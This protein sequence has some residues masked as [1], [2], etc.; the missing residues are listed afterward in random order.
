[1]IAH[2]SVKVR[3]VMELCKICGKKVKNLK[4]HMRYAHGEVKM[5]QRVKLKQFEPTEPVGL[6]KEDLLTPASKDQVYTCA[7]C[8]AEIK[9]KQS[10]C[11]GCGQRLIWEGIL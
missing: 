5:T 3:C 8:G 6:T 4:L 1:M 2:I 7:D 11:P 10:H 9:P